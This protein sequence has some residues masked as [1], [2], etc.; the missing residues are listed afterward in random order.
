MTS[1]EIKMAAGASDLIISRAGSALFEIAEW[2]VPSL[3]IPITNT[4]LDHQKKNAFAYARAGG[5]IV[6][7]EAN[8]TANIVSAECER[9]MENKNL[10]DD[11]AEGAKA[12]AHGDAA[13]KIAKELVR[14]AL[15]HEK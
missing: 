9:I 4:N 8:L 7:E 11:M 3:I 13:E 12:F 1:L 6:I 10:W 5:C 15:E 2:Q 14:I